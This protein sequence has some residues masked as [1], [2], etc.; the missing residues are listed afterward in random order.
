MCLLNITVLKILPVYFHLISLLLTCFMMFLDAYSY[1]LTSQDLF[2]LTDLFL[3]F[4]GNLFYFV[5]GLQLGIIG[6]FPGH[7]LDLTLCFVK[8]AFYFVLRAGFH[9]IPPLGNV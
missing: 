5:F 8:R 2:D 7:F 4:A 9:I 6:D 1:P 3:S